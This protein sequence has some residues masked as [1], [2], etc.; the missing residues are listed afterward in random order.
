MNY[1]MYIDLGEGDEKM[2]LKKKS[3]LDDDKFDMHYV[4]PTT[5]TSNV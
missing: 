3:R 5:T 2:I 4:D 1:S